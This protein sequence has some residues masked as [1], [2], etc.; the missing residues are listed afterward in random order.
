M[1]I[2]SQDN[3]ISLKKFYVT[4]LYD[5]GATSALSVLMFLQIYFYFSSAACLSVNLTVKVVL[6][7]TKEQQTKRHESTVQTFLDVNSG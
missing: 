7:R 5:A 6:V 1:H 3:Y 2:Y 4:R